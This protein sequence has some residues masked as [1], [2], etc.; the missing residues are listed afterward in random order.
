MPKTVTAKPVPCS[1][2][3]VPCPLFPVP[4]SLLI[5]TI[6]HANLLNY[7]LPPLNTD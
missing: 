6:F 1:L 2:S 4:C 5:T 3:P 7:Q